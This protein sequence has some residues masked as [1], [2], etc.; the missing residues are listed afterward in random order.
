M[1]QGEALRQ[2]VSYA[3]CRGCPVSLSHLASDASRTEDLPLP[4]HARSATVRH[5]DHRS[6]GGTH[7]QYG[8]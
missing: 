4:Q 5:E 8:R 1:S 2:A 7:M 3:G 6:Q